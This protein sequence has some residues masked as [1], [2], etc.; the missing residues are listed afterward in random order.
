MK[1]N[2]LTLLP[3]PNFCQLMMAIPIA[4]LADFALDKAKLFLSRVLYDFIYRKELKLKII[5]QKYFKIEKVH[6]F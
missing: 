3:S 1:D 2:S 4:I 6:V 5:W